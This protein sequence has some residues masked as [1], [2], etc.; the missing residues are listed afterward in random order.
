MTSSTAHTIEMSRHKSPPEAM[1]WAE[2]TSS[3]L[4]PAKEHAVVRNRRDDHRGGRGG[5]QQGHEVDH[6]FEVV[7]RR[8][9]R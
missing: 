2:R 9:A 3:G 7:N 1:R 8:T 6:A 5:G 4:R